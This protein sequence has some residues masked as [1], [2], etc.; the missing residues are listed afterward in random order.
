MIVC[1]VV[2]RPEFVI[3]KTHLAEEG[4]SFAIEVH[5][6]IPARSSAGRGASDEYAA[7]ALQ[8]TIQP[9]PSC[10]YVQRNQWNSCEVSGV[11]HGYR[12]WHRFWKTEHDGQTHCFGSSA[13]KAGFVENAAQY[14]GKSA[15][16]T[17]SGQGRCD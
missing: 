14:L 2:D 6:M 4:A 15:G 16:K 7:K 3:I 8:S 17:K 5:L 1:A 12:I 13:C 9:R 11:W 10:V